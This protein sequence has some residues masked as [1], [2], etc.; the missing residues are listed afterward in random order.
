MSDENETQR[1]FE[2]AMCRR[3]QHG[4]LAL[5]PFVVFFLALAAAMVM[6]KSSGWATAAI[7]VAFLM[8]P[9]GAAARLTVPR[10]R[11][12]ECKEPV[13]G[14]LGIVCPEC[15]AT[16]LERPK[17]R[18]P[19]HCKGCDAWLRFH[20]GAGLWNIAYCTFCGV[21]LHEPAVWIQSAV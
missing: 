3:R 1:A 4:H 9:V 20:K 18:G 12:P 7:G 13:L 19:L 14:R 2:A 6:P 5:I 17:S 21:R 8:L 15:G 11:C 16:G 10:L